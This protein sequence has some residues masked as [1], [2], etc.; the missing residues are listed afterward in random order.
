M[1]LELWK[2]SV[3]D[4]IGL[5]L[6]KDLKMKIVEEGKGM[7][8]FLKEFVL[9][10]VSYQTML[11]ISM[12]SKYIFQVFEDYSIALYFRKFYLKKIFDSMKVKDLDL[13]PYN[14][15]FYKN[16]VT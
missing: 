7:Y 14:Y 9:Y 1:K 4:D 6:S 2:Q 3:K 15:I 10:P 11:R 8:R 5:I 16:I 13:E 12:V